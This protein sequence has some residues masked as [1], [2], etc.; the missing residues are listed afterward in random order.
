MTDKE[1]N[2][3]PRERY[4]A[5][6][7]LMSAEL[8]RQFP[9]CTLE[10]VERMKAEQPDM[11]ETRG[12][13]VWCFNDDPDGDLLFTMVRNSWHEN[14]ED[15]VEEALRLCALL[16]YACRN[17]PEV[18]IH[19]AGQQPSVEAPDSVD[20]VM[21]NEMAEA[22]RLINYKGVQV[23]LTLKDHAFDYYAPSSHWA[24]TALGDTCDAD[25]AFD[26]RELPEVP[27]DQ[28]DKYAAL[29]STKPLDVDE[30]DLTCRLAYA[31][32]RGWLTKRGYE[33]PKEA[34]S[35]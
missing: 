10:A 28:Q 27:A 26:L 22:T 31:I 9:E 17:K 8:A 33:P 34:H 18:V 6:F 32:D 20:V 19:H 14:L 4:K 15:L 7:W 23:Y 29:F 12:V 2:A 5:Y 3:P 21:I 11:Y 1:L 35:G 16:N 13:G 24:S 25:E 30:Y